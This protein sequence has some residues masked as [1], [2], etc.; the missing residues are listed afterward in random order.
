MFAFYDWIN[1]DL[2]SFKIV[3]IYNRDARVGLVVDEKIIADVFAV[4]LG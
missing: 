4:F 1:D 3:Q 2:C